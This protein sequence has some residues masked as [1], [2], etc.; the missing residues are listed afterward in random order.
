MNYSI[1]NSENDLYTM[2]RNHVISLELQPGEM[3]SEGSMSSK[4][5]ASRVTVREAITQ[6]HEEGYIEVF[7]QK[8]T[9][10]TQIDMKR[11]KQ[12]VYAHTVLEQEI[13]E[14][15]MDRGFSEIELEIVEGILKEQKEAEMQ[16][17]M[18]GVV[19]KEYQIMYQLSTFCEKEFIWDFFRKMDSD[20]LRSQYLHHCTYS[21]QVQMSSGASMEHSILE[22]RLQIDNFIRGDK[23][24]AILNC[25]NRLA[26]V[27]WQAEM[28][29]GI[30]PQYFIG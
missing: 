12:A 29:K 27:M 20:L 19:L 30:Y 8:G 24:A 2:I 5:N 23:G 9:F 18:I 11:I 26:R 13:I 21:S 14:E 4:L 3:F 22:N 15:I 1:Y 25:V 10:V 6:L 7:P 17:D 28:M 16:E